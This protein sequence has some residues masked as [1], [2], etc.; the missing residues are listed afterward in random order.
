MLPVH[1]L[2]ASRLRSPAH[3]MA[4]GALVAPKVFVAQ[5]LAAEPTPGGFVLEG[6]RFVRAWLQVMTQRRRG[7]AACGV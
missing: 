3:R 1:L 5:A 7:V 4:A 6:V 2:P